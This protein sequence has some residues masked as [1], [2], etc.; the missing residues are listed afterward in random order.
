MEILKEGVKP[1]TRK[2]VRCSDCGCVWIAYKQEYRT[3]PGEYQ[4]VEYVCN[5]PCCGEITFGRTPE[6]V[7]VTDGR[8]QYPEGV[9]WTEL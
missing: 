7:A 8:L 1:D 9:R 4:E 3:R 5:C 2:Q 6:Q